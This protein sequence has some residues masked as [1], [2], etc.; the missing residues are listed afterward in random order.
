MFSENLHVNEKPGD[1][2]I[3]SA[4]EDFLYAFAV[5]GDLGFWELFWMKAKSSLTKTKGQ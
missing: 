3:N 5:T 1:T 2:P 4:V